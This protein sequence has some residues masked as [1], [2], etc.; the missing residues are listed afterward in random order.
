MDYAGSL[1]VFVDL[2]GLICNNNPLLLANLTRVCKALNERLGNC[3]VVLEGLV[4]AGYFDDSN[5]IGIIVNYGNPSQRLCKIYCSNLPA[6]FVTLPNHWF[7]EDGFELLFALLTA[8]F[9]QRANLIKTLS[10]CECMNVASTLD[11]VNDSLPLS[12]FGVNVRRLRG[13]LLR[14]K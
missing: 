6:M 10:S 8:S 3:N 12:H 14:R 2:S 4:T 9:S 5:I 7:F 11:F 1:C 13:E